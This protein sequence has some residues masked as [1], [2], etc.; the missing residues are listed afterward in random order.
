MYKD[1]RYIK[2]M[3]FPCAV[4]GHPSPIQPPLLKRLPH[5]DRPIRHTKVRRNRPLTTNATSGSSLWPRQ[6]RENTNIQN[7]S[8]LFNLAR[9]Q[10]HL[11]NTVLARA[12]LAIGDVSLGQEGLEGGV[13]EEEVL[14]GLEGALLRVLVGANDGIDGAQFEEFVQDAVDGDRGDFDGDVFPV[15]EEAGLEFAG[16]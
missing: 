2:S 15:G 1:L 13:D 10:V 9:K 7:T 5:R 3:P 16:V 12:I 6:S 8:D 11:P 4:Q 14:V